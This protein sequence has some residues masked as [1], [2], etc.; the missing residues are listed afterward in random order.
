MK[1]RTIDLEDPLKETPM[2]DAFFIGYQDITRDTLP[3]H[4][5]SSFSK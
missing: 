2:D 5:K 4:Q 3:V 1:N